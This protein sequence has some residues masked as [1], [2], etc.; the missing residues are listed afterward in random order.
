MSLDKNWVQ[1][2]QLGRVK[3]KK[4]GVS[5]DKKNGMSLDKKTEVSLDKKLGFFEKN[6]I[7][8]QDTNIH[9]HIKECMI[10]KR[11]SIHL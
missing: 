9:I 2:R 8:L 1:F 7:R 6:T 10:H 5:L 3:T 4:T 11:N